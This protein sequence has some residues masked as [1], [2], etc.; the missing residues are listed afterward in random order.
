MS[1]TNRQLFGGEWTKEKL[2]RLAKYLHAYTTIFTRNPGARF[3]DTVYVDAF[4]GAGYIPTGK[5]D[6]SQGALFAELT[7]QDA[8]GYIKGSAVRAL[9]VEPG[10]DKYLFIEK[11][12]ERFKELENLKTKYPTKKEKIDIVNGNANEHLREW[13]KNTNWRKTRAVVFLDP[14]GMEVEW[15]LLEA[16]AGTHGIDL[17]FLFPLGIAVMRLLTSREPPPEAWASRLTKILGTDEWE[18]RVL[19]ENSTTWFVRRHREPSK[20]SGLRGSRG[21][22][23]EAS[24][25][26][27]RARSSETL[28]A[29]QFQEHASLFVLFCGRQS[30]GGAHGG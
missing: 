8:Q 9:E 20:R 23:S 4:A 12:A 27:L 28:R 1:D 21:I 29:A 11:S 18:A 26:D 16:I 25:E 7:Q 17:W 14:Y 5:T 19:P 22:L 6:P 3:F 2:D 13:C 30:E 15:S 24:Q 10:F